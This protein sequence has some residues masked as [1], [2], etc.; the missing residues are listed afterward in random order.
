MLRLQH[1]AKPAADRTLELRYDGSAYRGRAALAPGRYD[2]DLGPA[3]RS[4][5]LAGAIGSAPT[6]VHVAAAPPQE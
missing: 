2:F 5:R 1:A 4:W 3:D 6:T